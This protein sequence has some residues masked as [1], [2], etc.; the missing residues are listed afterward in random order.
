MPELEQVDYRVEV[1]EWEE[2]PDKPGYLQVKRTKTID[3]V[4]RE[5]IGIVGELGPGHDEYFGVMVNVTV[6]REWPCPPGSRIV[7]FSVTGSSEGDY[8]H[9][10]V[11]HDRKREL[12]LLAKTFDGRDASWAFARRLADLLEVQ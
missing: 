4:C 5:L 8:T 7:V 11:H 6:N 3:E 10:E 12:L 2:V 1:Q 9:V